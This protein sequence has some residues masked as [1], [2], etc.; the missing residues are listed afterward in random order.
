MSTPENH[1]AA[2]RQCISESTCDFSQSPDLRHVAED[3]RGLQAL[4]LR[5]AKALDMVE[6]REELPRG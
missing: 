6:M 3:I 1:E 4:V 2:A 5:L